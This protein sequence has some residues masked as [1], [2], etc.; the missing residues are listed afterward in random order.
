[1]VSRDE[2]GTL[3]DSSAEDTVGVLTVVDPAVGAGVVDPSAGT[4]RQATTPDITTATSQMMRSQ[5]SRIGAFRRTV[6]D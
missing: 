6:E 3:G 1:V 2:G 5:R 4:S